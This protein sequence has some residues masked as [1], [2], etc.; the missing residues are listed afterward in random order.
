MLPGHVFDVLSTI[1]CRVRNNNLPFGGIQL[2]LCGD[3]LQLPPVGMNSQQ[4]LEIPRTF[5]FESFTW[6]EIF[7]DYTQPDYHTAGHSGSGMMILLD[8]IFRQR[9][10]SFLQILS[11]VRINKLSA[12]SIDILNKKSAESTSSSAVAIDIPSS[13]S[14][15]SSAAVL[16]IQHTKLFAT[17]K[18][19]D[20][21]NH[22]ELS[23]LAP[24][25]QEPILSTQAKHRHQQQQQKKIKKILFA[26]AAKTL[27]TNSQEPLDDDDEEDN[28]IITLD[29]E[30]NQSNSGGGSQESDEDGDGDKVEPE[31]ACYRYIAQDYG[32]AKYLNEL[33]QGLKAPQQ[34]DLKI[35][36]QVM[37]IKNLDV[38]QG[39]VNGARGI[40]VD[41][42]HKRIDEDTGEE[43][44]NDSGHDEII[45][46]VRFTTS[47]A[48]KQ[49]T[50]IRMLGREKWELSENDRELASRVQIPLIF[51]WAISVHKS[52]G[53]T[54]PFLDLSFK[55][56]FEYGQAYVALS[57][58]TDLNKGLILRN[59]SPH[60]IK[61]SY[62]VME[63]YQ[64]IGL[65][66]SASTSS[67]TSSN[68]PSEAEAGSESDLVISSYADLLRL[69]RSLLELQEDESGALF[70]TRQNYT[71]T[72]LVKSKAELAALDRGLQRMISINN[73]G[74]KLLRKYG[75]KG[76]GGIGE[77][78]SGIS[79]PITINP[80]AIRQQKD[81]SGLGL[82]LTTA[83]KLYIDPRGCNEGDNK[84]S[85][86]SL[87]DAMV[88]DDEDYLNMSTQPMPESL[89]TLVDLTSESP[90]GNET[91]FSLSTT[92]PFKISVSEIRNA[93][94]EN[95]NRYPQPIIQP[96]S[97][98]P[99]PTPTA[100]IADCI[101]RSLTHEEKM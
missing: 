17:N 96:S 3:F 14:A 47:I 20:K 62:K 43:I 92:T 37:L 98:A 38:G 51:A 28:Q 49:S 59:F 54:I 34:L 87:A 67:S 21:Y 4:K 79:T 88:D 56:M 41:F 16:R 99:T 65:P 31:I 27:T 13:S 70:F 58:A 82:G 35:G 57:R 66:A 101:P 91:P 23:K 78:E 100:S 73:K 48:N 29:D 89:I 18:D 90:T 93:S 22:D 24:H 8:R 6:K 26:S 9:D 11:E 72:P 10:N 75:Y 80:Q 95:F 1:A 44:T 84:L 25:D 39:L 97:P 5:C 77:D 53:M 19:V 45:P 12:K 46:V 30:E 60:A 63:F 55:G 52:Q 32:E 83:S 50:V 7:G 42:T 33:L 40:I 85:A 86:T 61:S 68:R 64:M 69:Y 2:L 36:A 15:S 94:T 76:S 71:G 81:S 74:S